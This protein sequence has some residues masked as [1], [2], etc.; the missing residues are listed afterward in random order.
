MKKTIKTL[1]VKKMPVF[2]SKYLYY[3]TFKKRLDLKKP[4]TFNEKLMWLKL[5][6]DDALKTKCTDKY[7]VRNYI[8]K[9]GYSELLIELDEVYEHV[10]EIDFTKLPKSFVMK[11]SHGSGFNIICPDKEKLDVKQVK[12]Q[13]KKWLQ[14]DYGSLYCEPHYSPIT[15]RITVE[16]F[17]VDEHEG[18]VPI[19]YMIHCFHGEPYV[20]EVGVD[21]EGHGKKYSTYN[22]EWDPLPYYKD[23]LDPNGIIKKPERLKEMLIISKALSKA[24]TYVRV[25]LYYCQQ[26][27]FGE[28]TFTPGACLEKDFVQD[29]EYRMGELLDLTI[30]KK[31]RQ[32][33][34]SLLE[35]LK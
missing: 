35:Y 3:M 18:Q 30:L 31:E 24:F 12:V 1:L 28:L 27:Y 19:D 33:K 4:T 22:C 20:I 16:R 13:L 5:F 29:G 34:V 2:I 11:C 25:D 7:L 6:E 17:L 26:I 9:L 21:Y 8:S 23:S 14:T 32:P 15:P 10:E